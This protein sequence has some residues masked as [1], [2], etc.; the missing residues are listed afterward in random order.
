MARVPRRFTVTWPQGIRWPQFLKLQIYSPH[1]P[2]K[3]EN[4]GKGVLCLS[5][6]FLHFIH[7]PANFISFHSFQILKYSLWIHFTRDYIDR[8]ISNF[9]AL[10]YNNVSRDHRGVTW[11]RQLARST[12]SYIGTAVERAV[13]DNITCLQ[14]FSFTLVFSSAFLKEFLFLSCFNI[15]FPSFS[16]VISMAFVILARSF[17]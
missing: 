1:P 14:I 15:L 9:C 5:A 3:E 4:V 17:S 2:L 10:L 12:R 8:L 11:E 16:L 6:N 13:E 7:W